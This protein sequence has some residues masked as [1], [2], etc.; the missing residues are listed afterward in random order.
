MLWNHQ[1]ADEE[2]IFQ[3]SSEELEQPLAHQMIGPTPSN[4]HLCKT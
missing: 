1:K 4:V 2:L 3:E